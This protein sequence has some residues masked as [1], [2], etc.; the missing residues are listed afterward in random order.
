MIYAVLNDEIGTILNRCDAWE[1]DG[2]L[3]MAKWATDNG[4][5]ILNTEI[6]LMGDMVIWC[7]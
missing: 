7:E 2:D 5:T 6:T 1:R 3:R 4:Y